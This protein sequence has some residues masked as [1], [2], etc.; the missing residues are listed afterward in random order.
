MNLIKSTFNDVFDPH[1]GRMAT[2]KRSYYNRY[3]NETQIQVLQSNMA[4]TGRGTKT[5]F[6]VQPTLHG[7][8]QQHA[9]DSAMREIVTQEAVIREKLSVLEGLVEEANASPLSPKNR[10]KTDRLPN[11]EG[12]HLSH[13]VPKPKLSQI[14]SP[15][16]VGRHPTVQETSG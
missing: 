13:V 7:L 1:A 14:T 4:S 9:D 11:H 3:N 8:R 15:L 2:R 16:K 6:S 10:G 5:S 12:S